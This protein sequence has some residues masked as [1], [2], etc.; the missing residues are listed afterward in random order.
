MPRRNPRRPRQRAAAGSRGTAQAI[1]VQAVDLFY[2]RGYEAATL[3]DVADAAGVK[4]A[5]LYNYIVSKQE[6][7]F[8]VMRDVLVDLHRSVEQAIAGE[9]DPVAQLRAAVRAHMVFHARRPKEVFVG[10]TELRSLTPEHR[11]VIVGLRDAYEALF[12]GVLEEGQAAGV[13]EVRDVRVATYAVLAMCSGPSAWFSR[14][15]RVAVREMVGMY[16]RLILRAV[17]AEDE[18]AAGAPDPHF[19]ASPDAALRAACA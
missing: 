8:T 12:R 9:V 15:G 13:F 6:L 10:N 5:T 14:R 16:T 2:Q 3:R 4:V 17:G 19:A 11:D 18:E 7:L 1:F